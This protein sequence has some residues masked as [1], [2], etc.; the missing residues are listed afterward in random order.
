MQKNFLQYFMF[1]HDANQSLDLIYRLASEG[2][3]GRCCFYV[4]AC[5]QAVHIASCFLPAVP[6]DEHTAAAGVA[7]HS[8]LVIV[9]SARVCG[10]VG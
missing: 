8:S 5:T 9:T 10:F 7:S 2:G 4:D 6:D 3:I 1:I